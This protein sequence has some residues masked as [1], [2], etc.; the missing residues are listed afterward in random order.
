MK[1]AAAMTGYKLFFEVSGVQNSIQLCR[2][3]PNAC[4]HNHDTNIHCISCLYISFRRAYPADVPRPETRSGIPARAREELPAC[5]FERNGKLYD[6]EKA[7]GHIKEKYEYFRDKITST[8]TFIE[9][10]A[11]KSMMSG[12]YYL[13]IC[14]GKEP[15][16]TADWLLRSSGSTGK[17]AESRFRKLPANPKRPA[18][19]EFSPIFCKTHSA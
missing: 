5:K 2:D 7:Y 12:K 10:A 15:E 9:Y 17:P 8:E 18:I 4:K 6:S 14:A 3:D 13:I 19:T 11:T 16:N 1:Y